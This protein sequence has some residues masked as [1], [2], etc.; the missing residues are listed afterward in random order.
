MAEFGNASFAND[1]NLAPTVGYVLSEYGTPLLEF[2]AT[3]GSSRC[4]RTRRGI[5]VISR[6]CR[7]A[8]E[9]RFVT[10][11]SPLP[12]GFT[13]VA[14]LRISFDALPDDARY[15]VYQ[16]ESGPIL[17]ELPAEEIRAK[18]RA[19]AEIEA[20]VQ[21]APTAQEVPTPTPM[22][23][24]PTPRPSPTPAPAPMPGPTLSLD[25]L[26]EQGERAWSAERYETA[27][28][29]FDE[30]I[31]RSPQSLG[32]LFGRAQTYYK[33]GQYELAMRDLDVVIRFDPQHARAYYLRGLIHGLV[34]NPFESERDRYRAEQLDSGGSLT[35]GDAPGELK[36]T[37]TPTPLIAL[38]RAPTAVTNRTPMVVA[39][40][41]P[42]GYHRSA[43]R[44]FGIELP[45]AWKV[46]NSFAFDFQDL[47][48]TEFWER[49]RDWEV[50]DWV[51]YQE[52]SLFVSLIA[53]RSD[54]EVPNISSID[55]VEYVASRF[56]PHIESD[57]NV[58]VLTTPVEPIELANGTAA[59]QVTWLVD[60]YTNSPFL[61]YGRGFWETTWI[62][63]VLSDKVITLQAFVLDFE[64]AGDS[65]L[66]RQEMKSVLSTF[67]AFEDPN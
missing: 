25:E 63:V 38:R 18:A 56:E 26:I 5:P 43:T 65:C 49:V 50:D 32:A 41:T 35:G 37:P 53:I 4:N 57:A 2:G 34:G 3:Y 66:S 7:S 23:I 29:H 46:T 14:A 54:T 42:E 15:L 45:P 27:L 1:L 8:R 67:T 58:R 6:E 21:S 48:N 39:T 12:P 10:E 61:R 62:V 47:G 19:I 22:R 55:P 9:F 11:R 52:A 24:S 40:P 33:L 59:T 51:A 28:E 13:T 16:F 31:R 60:F 36:P 30:A 64:C 44:G 17:I 20:A